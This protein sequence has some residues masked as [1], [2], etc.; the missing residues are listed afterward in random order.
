MRGCPTQ[1]GGF[2]FYENR[3]PKNSRMSLDKP[4]IYGRMIVLKGKRS[5]EEVGNHD[6]EN[7]NMKKFT[8]TVDMV[9][10]DLDCEKF[11][12]GLRAYLEEQCEDLVAQVKPA[13]IKTFSEQGFKVWRARVT[14]VTA[15]QAGD[16]HNAK[17]V[18]ETVG[19]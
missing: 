7:K 12:N 18:K 6:L 1:T 4:M 8:F 2:D 10:S 15:K 5:P 9:G 14:G 17:P 13:G 19:A 3:Q 16:A 11:T